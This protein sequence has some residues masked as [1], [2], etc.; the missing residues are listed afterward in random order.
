MTEQKE[1]PTVED[2]PGSTS[3]TEDRENPS[4]DDSRMDSRQTEVKCIAPLKDV[5]DFPSVKRFLDRIGGD[6]HSL[7]N[8]RVI[9]Y[10]YKYARTI[11]K[12]SF[13]KDGLVS[14]PEGFEPTPEEQNAISAEWDERRFPIQR[15]CL[16]TGRRS[17]P[18]DFAPWSNGTENE[19]YF[20]ARN[21]RGDE[22]LMVE[23]RIQ[24][25]DGSKLCI[26][27]TYWSDGK[28]RALAPDVF[29]VF[30][31]DRIK[32]AAKII[33]H[34]GPKAA[35]H[36]TDL[37]KNRAGKD[38]PFGNE[39]AGSTDG[40]VAHLGWPGGALNAGN[41]DWGSLKR[42][43]SGRRVIV[44]LD[45]DIPGKN[46][47]R[48]ISKALRCPL[49]ALVFTDDYPEGH[50]LADTPPD[51]HFRLVDGEKIYC[52]PSFRDLL[53]SAT[54]ATYFEHT[55]RDGR[56]A[57]GVTQQF[58]EEW[59]Y[60][61]ELGMYVNVRKPNVLYNK[62]HFNNLVRPVSDAADTANA[63]LQ[64]PSVMIDGLTYAPGK[65]E[66][67]INV[68]GRQMLNVWK[69]TRIRP[70]KGDPRPFIRFLFHLVPSRKERRVLQKWIATL[71]AK[72]EIRMAYAVMLKSEAQ[73][74][75]KTT[76]C[77]IL[78]ELVGGQNA[79]F[80]SQSSIFNS[81]YTHWIVNKRLIV[82][83]ELFDG[84]SGKAN[85][86]FLKDKIT[87]PIV[88]VNVKYQPQF[89]SPNHAHFI[90]NSNEDL[91]AF[92]TKGDRRWFIPR[93]TEITR[94][95]GYWKRLHDWL[96]GDGHAI[97]HQWAIDHVIKYGFVSAGETA[98]TTTEK[99]KIIEKSLSDGARLLADLSEALVEAGIG[100]NPQRIAMRID[101]LKDYIKSEI[102]DS[103]STLG[104]R[105]INK[106]LS[107][108]GLSVFSGDARPKIGGR[109][110]AI[111]LNFEPKAGESLSSSFAKHMK[112]P[113]DYFEEGPF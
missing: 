66:G 7:R 2:V 52:G 110:V 104:V 64:Q 70:M 68:N 39:L 79:S 67:V 62:E 61:S 58:A 10:V 41:V 21:T 30:G 12:I 23:Q 18:R 57:I 13:G 32:H 87:D 99:S 109:K 95:H 40:A 84:S 15:T 50:D 85:L 69:P 1:A 98:P 28:W 8:A 97:I 34:E 75:G 9:E 112:K 31:L 19:D 36:L 45:N 20:I 91:P 101:D 49:D 103:R 111:L 11:A 25:D 43:I 59:R 93:L 80:P 63:V 74:V 27:W 47:L 60:L 42:L 16:Y 35:A 92:L 48:P 108:A 29:P 26:P 3:L 105:A 72:P 53:Q 33:I 56:P 37:I 81:S 107:D 51:D 113:V 77:N 86:N 82:V 6:P 17:P 71:I 24:N 102:D 106:G 44:A 96:N 94:S 22:I 76:L 46:A 14:A 73:G 88:E 38:H 100:D 4:P 65:P 78:A 90:I 55:G 54:W 83:N 89:T 5:N